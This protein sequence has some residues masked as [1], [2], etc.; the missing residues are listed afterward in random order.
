MKSMNKFAEIFPG[1]RH[2]VLPVIHVEN[3]DQALR[4][5]KVAQASG[6]DGVFLINHGTSYETLLTIHQAVRKVL[7]DWWIGVNCLDLAPAQVF[8]TVTEKVSGIWVDNAA[9]DERRKTQPEA[10]MIQAAR[11]QSG[12]SGLYFGGVAFKYQRPVNDLAGAATLAARFMDVVTTS[13]PA[14]GA[15]ATLKQVVEMKAAL[16]DFPLAVAS[17]ITPENVVDYLPYVDCFMVATGISWS[18]SEL[19]PA[20]IEALMKAVRSTSAGL[21]SSGH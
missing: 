10:E 18:W 20:K 9:I 14:T 8:L 5:A 13:G 1:K 11:Q 15:A 3:E 2:V 16:G 17:G 19:D 4:N 7:P 12:W 6:A 21:G